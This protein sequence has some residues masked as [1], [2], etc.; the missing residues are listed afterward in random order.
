MN[1]DTPVIKISPEMLRLVAAIDEFKGSWKALQNIAPDRLSLLRKVATIESV[2]SS[3]RIEG[4]KLTDGEIERLLSGTG[5]KRFRSRDE[6]EVAGYAE[7]MNLIFESYRDIPITENHIRQLHQILLKHSSKDTRHR[8]EYKKL[9]NH[10]EAFEENGKSVG[11][12]FETATPFDTPRKMAEL[13]EWFDRETRANRH[14]ILIL[15]AVFIVHFL[16]IH[17]FQDGNGRLSRVLTTLCLMRAGYLYA[18][19][20]SL[21]RVIE[22]HKDRYYLTLR[23]AQATLYTSNA[24]LG[25]WLL[26]FLQSLNNQV[27]VLAGKLGREKDL[28]E[29]PKLSQD[30]LAAAREQGRITV[31]DLCR[32]TGA[33]RN[34]IKAHLKELV[35]QKK[36]FREGT[37]KGSWYR[38]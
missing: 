32:L 2:G 8:G 7:A 34:T 4:V 13:V 3:T 12:I 6:Q 24:R 29:I 35:R 17:P 20:C 25:V 19:Y 27:N 31:R 37:G 15:I 16:A 33:N 21:E 5:L 28:L 30:I 38:L 36:L 23:R 1:M 14:H 22:E 11:V 26:F 10:V 18:P 9:P